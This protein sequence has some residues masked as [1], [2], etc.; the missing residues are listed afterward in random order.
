VL[1][2]A[3]ADSNLEIP[4]IQIL[5]DAKE[6]Y[7]LAIAISLAPERISPSYLAQAIVEEDAGEAARQ[8]LIAT[9]L[10]QV[11]DLAAAFDHLG[12][13][14]EALST[15][16]KDASATRARRL[17]RI[18]AKLRPAIAVR[19]LPAG[20]ELGPNLAKFVRALIRRDLSV[21]PLRSS[22]TEAALGLLYELVRARFSLVS[23]PETFEV[24]DV[25]RTQLGIQAWPTELDQ[26]V[27]RIA[28]QIL[29]G[30]ELL[31]RQ[32]VTDSRIRSLV[33]RLLGPEAGGARLRKIAEARP[34]LSPQIATWLATGRAPTRAPEDRLAAES[35]LLEFDAVVGSMM[36]ELVTLRMAVARLQD[37]ITPQIEALDPESL[38]ISRAIVSGVQKLD[39]RL[40][41]ISSRRSLKMRGE[42]GDIV[43]FSPNEHEQTSKTLGSRLV[44]IG[45]PLIERSSTGLSSTVI[46]KA[47]VDPA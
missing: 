30:I 17:V 19:D 37:E 33:I 20:E 24:V 42:V 23:S 46:L 1:G 43:E 14:A 22:A 15:D 2:R 9:L 39:E 10:D 28:S 11:P 29:E 44:R 18:A 5:M 8:V 7:Y 25:L 35:I 12:V 41:L 32:G 45:S 38:A 27:Q 47:D 31:A 26:A 36:R 13:C 21:R 6:R 34:G 3:L 40:R 16:T 4:N